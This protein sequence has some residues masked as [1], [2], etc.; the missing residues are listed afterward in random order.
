MIIFVCH[1][2]DRHGQKLCD[3]TVPKVV[4]RLDKPFSVVVPKQDNLDWYGNKVVLKIDY[5]YDKEAKSET[6][7]IPY[8]LVGGGSGFPVWLLW[9]FLVPVLGVVLFLLVRKIID[10]TNPRIVEHKIMLTIEDA[11]DGLVPNDKEPYTLT[12]KNSLVFGANDAHE[13]HFDVGWPDCPN[14]LRCER[15]SVFP[16]SKDKGRIR[17]HKS[18]DDTEGAVVNPPETLTLKRDEDNIKVCIQY[19]KEDNTSDTKSDDKSFKGSTEHVDPL[20]V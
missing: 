20:K 10:W 16:W 12:D 11:T 1:I 7:E 4:E 3:A 14:F 8:K 2:Q 17:H 13:L 6:I 9:V 18:I 5:K 15:N 19:D